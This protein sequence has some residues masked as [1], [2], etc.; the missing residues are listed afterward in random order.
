MLTIK[1]PP[2]VWMLAQ[3]MLLWVKRFW[4]R[5]GAAV[6]YWV[7]P[8]PGASILRMSNLMTFSMTEKML[9]SDMEIGWIC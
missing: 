9:P 2:I 1:A 3:T 4:G 7:R 8:V 6:G 5:W